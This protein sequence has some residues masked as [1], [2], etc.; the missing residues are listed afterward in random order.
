MKDKDRVKVGIEGFDVL[1]QGGFP[2]GK[3]VLLSGTAGTGKTIFALQ[4]LYKGAHEFNE[5]GLYITF[6]EGSENLKNQA[7]QFG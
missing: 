7:L 5:P 2:R 1:V 4:Y 6:E 3:I